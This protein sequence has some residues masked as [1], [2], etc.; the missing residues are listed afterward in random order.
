MVILHSKYL[1]K[2]MDLSKIKGI[3]LQQTKNNV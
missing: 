2:D 3:V 1:N